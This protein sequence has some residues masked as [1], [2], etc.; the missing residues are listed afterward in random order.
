VKGE[1][2]EVDDVQALVLATNSHNPLSTGEAEFRKALVSGKFEEMR[3]IR[4]REKRK[5][6]EKRNDD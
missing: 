3:M 4:R 2:A 6:M 5:R 1:P